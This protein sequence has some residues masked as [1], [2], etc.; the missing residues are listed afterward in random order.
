MVTFQSVFCTLF[1]EPT[2]HHPKKKILKLFYVGLI[3]FPIIPFIFWFEVSSC[4]VVCGWY[5]GDMRLTPDAWHRTFW[6]RPR[7]CSYIKCVPES[8]MMA[9]G[10]PNLAK[11]IFLDKINHNFRVNHSSSFLFNRFWHVIYR[12]QDINNTK[13]WW[14]WANKSILQTSKILSTRIGVSGIWFREFNDPVF[15]HRS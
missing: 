1:C 3:V 11:A 4:L 5:A 13:G 8:L 6:E 2:M 15:W 9:L 10:V 7:E 14:K 12:K